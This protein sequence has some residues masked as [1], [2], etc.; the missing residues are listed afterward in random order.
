MENELYNKKV[1][2]KSQPQGIN[3]IDER[4]KDVERPSHHCDICK[5]SFSRKA[6]GTESHYPRISWITLKFAVSS[7]TEI[8]V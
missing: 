3:F 4:S 8:T 7:Y 1:K 2:C 5:K 6:T